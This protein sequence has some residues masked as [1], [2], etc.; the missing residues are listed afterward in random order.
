MTEDEKATE[1]SKL[2]DSMNKLIESAVEETILQAKI[3][4]IYKICLDETREETQILSLK[5]D[6]LRRTQQGY[7]GIKKELESTT[8]WNRPVYELSLLKDCTLPSEKIK[9]LVNCAHAIYLSHAKEQR[10][11]EKHM[12]NFGDR[13]EKR[14]VFF[15]T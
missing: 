15:I 1:L 8:N 3:S 2:M 4:E 12:G 7:F 9:S 5:I 11:N 6:K 14:E 13:L 10:E